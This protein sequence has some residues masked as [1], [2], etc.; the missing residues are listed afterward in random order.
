M[1]PTDN[2]YNS[3]NLENGT[4]MKQNVYFTWSILLL[5]GVLLVIAGC[6]N[7]VKVGGTVKFDDGMP[8]DAGQV[9]MSNGT[10]MFQGKILSDGTFSIGEIKDGDGIPPGN[11]GIW[12]AGANPSATDQYQTLKIPTKYTNRETSGLTFEVK[13]NGTKTIDILLEKP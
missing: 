5:S 7:K 4:A 8:L 6:S 13:K 12:I 9:F 2:R 3:P 10:F 11:Y 1:S